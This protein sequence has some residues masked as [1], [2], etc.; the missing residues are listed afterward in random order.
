MWR[1]DAFLRH[2][3][4]MRDIRPGSIV[5]AWLQ[6]G[7]SREYCYVEMVHN[8]FAMTIGWTS[9]SLSYLDLL[10]MA[11]PRAAESGR[12]VRRL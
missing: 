3:L 2:F 10:W 4:T 11:D 9:L 1:T 5:H 12:P 6:A 7:A 8:V